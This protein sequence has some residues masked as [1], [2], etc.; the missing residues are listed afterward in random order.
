MQTQVGKETLRTRML[1]T[2]KKSFRFGRF[3][4]ATTVHEPDAIGHLARKAHFMGNAPVSYTHLT[5]P[6]KA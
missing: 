2:A 1:G 5:L 6:T 4:D 3:E